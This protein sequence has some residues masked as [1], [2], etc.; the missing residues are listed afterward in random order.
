MDVLK[1]IQVVELAVGVAGG[2]AGMFMADFGAEVI[3][4]EQP[5]GD[6]T[7]NEPGFAVW[8]RGKK[9]VVVDS[10][11]AADGRRLGKLLRGADICIVNSL[12][13][14]GTYWLDAESLLRDNPRLILLV[15]SPYGRST[16]WAG[17][18]ESH[19]LLSATAGVAWRQ[20]STDGGP[21]EI[22]TSFLLCIQGTWA[23][24]C[25]VAA[26]IER[27][28]SG[29]GQVIQVSG[30]HSVL[31]TAA[32]VL[33]VNPDN[34][35][36]STAVGSGGRHPTYTRYR[37]RDGKWLACGALGG[38]F[39]AKLLHALGLDH[40]LQDPRIQG[41]TENII[42]AQN[43]E[44]VR[45]LVG[46]AFAERDHQD[47]LKSI[48]ALGI[49]C[50]VV[51]RTEDWLDHEQVRAVGMCNCQHDPDRGAV[52]MIGVPIVLEATPGSV[53]G[54][55]PR[56]GEHTRAIST[57]KPAVSSTSL[58]QV[59]PGPLQG[60]HVLDIGTFVAGP[61]AGSLLAELGANVIKV[62]PPSGDPFR[63]MGF[64]YNRG[65]RSLA[66]DLQTADGLEAL[67]RV[68]G[69]IDLVIDS[70]RPGVSPRLRISHDHLRKHKADIVTVSLSAFGESGPLA[71]LPGVDMV[72]QA[73]SG[74]MAHQGGEDE[75]V[76]STN[77]VVD[78]AT[79]TLTV[80]GGLLGLLHRRRTSKGQRLSVSLLGAAAYL[81]AGEMVRYLGRAPLGEGAPNYRGTAW[82]DRFYPT[83]DGWIRIHQPAADSRSV[84]MLLD[85]FDIEYDL[86][87]SERIGA[88]ADIL[89][90]SKANEV[91]SQLRRCGIA[92]ARAR[93]VSEFVREAMGMDEQL[94]DVLPACDG[95]F[96]VAPGRLATFSRT[97][98]SGPMVVPGIGEH[99]VEVLAQAGIAS[100]DIDQ[101][102]AEGV[103]AVGQPWPQK[104][105]VAYR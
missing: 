50:A 43:V 103:V 5:D 87:Q 8:N 89:L 42:Q 7:R 17:G 88:F 98:R 77:P 69:G 2:S 102:I 75:P 52:S 72:I 55:A 82:L 46:E 95:S 96:F 20:A 21:V 27:E 64:I 29:Q 41:A 62:E 16:P 15:V 66:L 58:P 39:E 76:T 12:S 36:V 6:P 45:Q 73:M 80:L 11:N 70:L 101:L 91:V 53:H 44:W 90:A 30:L 24:A 78:V 63:Q 54:P 56:L 19:A 3:K 60:Y 37:T 48:S 28:A 68:V 65:M 31:L 99:S 23:A 79:A 49:P 94:L 100:G 51:G 33:A 40:I 13:D 83:M 61:Y 104:L 14:L 97:V 81:Q 26:L 47:L 86:A 35:D 92:A 34:P 84:A 93:R 4:I 25:A 67:H 22:R 57:R 85:H 9:S 18:K 105:F 59:R 38:K 10:L 74:M 71:G 1:K 32:G